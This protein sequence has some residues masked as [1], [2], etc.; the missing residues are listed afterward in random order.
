MTAPPGL[1]IRLRLYVVP[2]AANAGYYHDSMS[3]TSSLICMRLEK[4]LVGRP[5]VLQLSGGSGTSHTS[6]PLIAR[7]RSDREAGGIALT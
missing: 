3:A 4:T 2:R 5:C 7:N 1:H 6:G